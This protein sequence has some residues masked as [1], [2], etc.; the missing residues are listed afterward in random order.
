MI[1]CILAAALLLAPVPSRAAAPDPV[2]SIEAR[3]FKPGEVILV[4][5]TGNDAKSPPEASLSGRPLTF[6]QG[7]S[8]GTW[9][10]FAGLDLDFST[11][12]AALNAVTRAP[13]GRTARSSE[14]LHIA[15]AGFPVVELTVEQKFVTPD[16]TDSE[17][18][19]AEAARLHKLFSKTEEKRLFDGRFDSPIPGA[20]TGRL[21]ERRVFNGQPRAPHSGMDLRAKLGVPVRAPAAGKVLLADPLFFAGKTIIIDHGLGI[22]TQYAHLSKFLVKAG[23]MVKKGQVIG[24]VGATGRVTGPH[25][26][27]AMKLKTARVDPYSLV[28]LDLDAKL[29]PRAEDPLTRSPLCGRADLPRAPRWSKPSRGLRARA[30]PTKAVYAP[31]EN[32]SLLVEIQNIGK[33]AAF[34]D[35]VRDAALRPLVLGVGEAPQAFETLLASGTASGALT[36][37]IKIPRNRIL[38]FEQDQASSGPLL[39]LGT[40]SYVLSYGTENLYPSTST[41]RAGLWRGRLAIPPA[42][43]AVSTGPLSPELR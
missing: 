34:V 4:T 2:L 21:G 14:T 38:C 43:V 31:G 28:H 39:A 23:D 17:R 8:T 10:A 22:T 16:K 11:G 1:P 30:R 3:A 33:K 32:V 26:H 6:F 7:P 15:D 12:P 29:K 40:T 13:D 19:E 42:S 41:V 27:W 37:Q 9:L 24:K 5:V 18:A 36:E 20:R 35:F 25:L